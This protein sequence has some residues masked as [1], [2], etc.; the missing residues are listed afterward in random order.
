MRKA[1]CFYLVLL[2]NF[3]G[4]LWAMQYINI[5]TPI[6]EFIPLTESALYNVHHHHHH[7]VPEGLGILACS[8][9]LKM[10]LVPPSLSRSSYVSS[11]VWSVF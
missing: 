10:K 11:S 8:L 2:D 7:H 5:I 1:L 3:E 9:I 4:Y 6:F